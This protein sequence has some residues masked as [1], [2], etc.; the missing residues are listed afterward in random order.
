M[1]SDEY[2]SDP[3]V[4]D[5]VIRLA[6]EFGGRVPRRVVASTV[7]AARRDLEGQVAPEAVAEMLHRLAHH[8]LDRRPRWADR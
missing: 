2:H 6:A 7:V 4:A 3:L 1:A 5:T 8:R